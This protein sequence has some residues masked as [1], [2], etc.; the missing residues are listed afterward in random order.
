MAKM[1]LLYGL[2][3]RQ[4]L[5]VAQGSSLMAHNQRS[6]N[7]R[8]NLAQILA[9]SKHREEF[10]HKSLLGSVKDEPFAPKCGHTRTSVTSLIVAS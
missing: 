4:K 5:L 3:Q 10:R 7:V 1:Y 9:Q 6:A 2:A 8:V